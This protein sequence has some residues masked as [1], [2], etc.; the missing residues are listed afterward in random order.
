M[1]SKSH[2]DYQ[3]IQALLE[4]NRVGIETIYQR[5]MKECINFMQKN[6]GSIEDAFDVFQ[7]SL[8]A[9][10]LFVR[11]RPNFILTAP[12]GGFLYG[13]YSRLWL[14][15]LRRRKRESVIKTELKE[16]KDSNQDHFDPSILEE[17]SQKQK[18]LYKLHQQLKRLSEICQKILKLTYW[19]NLK[20][21][22]IAPLLGIS[23]NFVS[24]QKKRCIKRLGKQM[25]S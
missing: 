4:N 6:S 12:F 24:V 19:K 22:D 9:I 1:Q 13:F 17:V 16:Y 2:P 21:R 23:A 11:K 20:P 10:V 18:Q 3:Y 5:F 14:R 7:E 8:M 15:E 25:L